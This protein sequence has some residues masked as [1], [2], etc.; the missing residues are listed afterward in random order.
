MATKR[1]FY[2]VL[3]VS[4]SASAE[5]IKKA[6]KKLALKNHPDRNPG[7]DDAVERFKEAAEAYEALSD[8]DK[9]ARYDRFGHDGLRGAGGPGGGTQFHDLNDIFESFGDIFGDM[10]GG[11]A[12]RGGRN[13]VVRGADLRAA[14]T[15]DLVAA[16]T[17]CEQDV[18][19]S[20]KKSC[21]RCAGSGAEPGTDPE[22]CDYC[23]GAGQVVQ[24]QGFFRIQTTCPACRGQGKIVRHKC[25]TCYGSGRESETV[26]LNV[27]IPPGMDN[28]M[29]LCLRGEGEAGPN[30]GPRGDLYVDVRVKE[31]PIFQR[32]ENHLFFKAPITYTQAVLGTTIEIPLIQGKD[33]LKVAA[34]TQPGE[35]IRLRG[36]GLPDPRTGHVGDL[37]VEIQVVVP[38]KVSEHHEKLLRDLAGHEE[39]EVHPHR[40]SWFDKLKDFFSSDVAD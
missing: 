26:T 11:G 27:K 14:V 15:I 5:E 2:E 28:G 32:R 19:L 22:Q 4:K 40:K 16:A 25:N 10:F 30:N 31:H 3:G 38:K 29:Q 8:P 34:G 24:A 1:D 18:K 33:E 7:D 35:T 9:R 21:Q 37:H 13:R 6:Y 17:G 23:G 39:S 12:R 20:R 36:K